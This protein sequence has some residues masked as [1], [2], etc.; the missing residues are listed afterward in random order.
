MWGNCKNTTNNERNN[1]SS[2]E[3]HYTTEM[4]KINNTIMNK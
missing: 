3:K 1:K 4:V 2:E